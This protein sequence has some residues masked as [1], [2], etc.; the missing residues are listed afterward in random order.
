LFLACSLPLFFTP[1]QRAVFSCFLV[2][3]IVLSLLITLAN[4]DHFFA[5][6]EPFEVNNVGCF[7]AYYLPVCQFYVRFF[8]SVTITRKSLLG[9]GGAGKEKGCISAPILYL[10]Y[11]GYSE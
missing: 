9:F 1:L 5:F 2:W 11:F 4:I 7:H 6:S 3:Y 8:Y 10:K